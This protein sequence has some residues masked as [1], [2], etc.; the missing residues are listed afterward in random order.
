MKQKRT[1]N[2]AR[3]YLTDKE[4]LDLEKHVLKYSYVSEADFLRISIKDRIKKDKK[5][6]GSV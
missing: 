4:K 2:T 3:T 5:K 1:S 6:T